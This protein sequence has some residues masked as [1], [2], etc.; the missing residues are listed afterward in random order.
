MKKSLYFPLLA[1]GIASAL[2]G[3]I[4]CNSTNDGLST[5]KLSNIEALAHGEQDEG[6]STWQVASKTITKKTITTTT[7]GWTYD[8]ELNVWL[9]KGQVTYS[10]PAEIQEIVETETFSCCRENGP[11]KT[12][13]YEEC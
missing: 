13:S 8:A 4:F 10:S 1:V 3:K 2:C 6:T 9:F 7:P 12:C 5:L 11:Y